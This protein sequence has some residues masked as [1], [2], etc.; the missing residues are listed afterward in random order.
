MTGADR[1][2]APARRAW[3]RRLGRLPAHELPGGL[4][5]HEARG[6]SARRRGL[7]GLDDLPAERALRLRC[8][9]VHTFTMR[10]ALDLIWLAGDGTVVRVDRGVRPRRHRGCAQARAVVEMRAGCADRYLAAGIGGYTGHR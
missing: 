7:G 1:S 8:R 5:V 9:A 2:A 4:C 10:F 6:V 3:E